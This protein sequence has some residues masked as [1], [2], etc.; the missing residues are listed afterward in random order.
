MKKF[1]AVFMALLLM[2]AILPSFAN[3]VTL[4]PSDVSFTDRIT[5]SDDGITWLDS[6]L[7]TWI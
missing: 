5:H 1:L 4:M 3:E 2:I 6:G 7:T